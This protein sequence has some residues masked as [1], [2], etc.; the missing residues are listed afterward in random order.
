LTGW[1][2]A[3]MLVAAVLVF[4]VVYLQTGASL[5]QQI[6]VDLHSDVNQ[7][8]GSLKARPG[9]TTERVRAR[10]VRYVHT[11]PYATISTLLFVLMPGQAPA[12]NHP[13]LFGALPPELGESQAVQTH[14]NREAAR[15]ARPRLGYSVGHVPDVGPM[16]ILERAARVGGVRVVAGAAEPLDSVDAAQR[17]VA[18]AF[19]LAGALALV[20]ALV[21]SYVAG[22]RVTA[23]LRRLAGVAARVDSGELEPRMEEPAG[24]GEEVR[25]LADAFNHMLDRLAVAF[26]GQREFMADASHELRTPLTVIRGQLE[27]LAATD[28]PSPEEVK[29]VERVVQAEV[30]RMSR[31]VDDLLLLTAAERSDFLRPEAIDVGPFAGELWDGLSLTAE[32]RFELGEVPEGTL[33]ADPDRVAQA[34]RNLG[35][36]AIDHSA[37]HTGLVRL[38]VTDLGSGRLSFAVVDDG[39]GIP[40]ADRERVFERL[41]RIDPSRSRVAGG[42]GLGLS[43]VR[44]IV[45]AHGGEV[46]IDSVPG[47]RGARVEFVLPG[48]VAAPGG[49]APGP[50]Y[51]RPV[52]QGSNLADSGYTG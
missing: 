13:E 42:A 12:S 35:R 19:G 6:D 48:F 3:V 51:P 49:R 34:I 39:P 10:A 45:E 33:D 27:V 43:I 16:R 8:L 50:P 32:R 26:Q 44:A 28:R 30:T 18:R 20:L 5:Q 22:E 11:Q 40:A 36:N 15:L 21:A 4:A 38:E 37:E 14:E 29:R 7:M 46:K 52:A 23:P 31:L 24:G 47:G 9:H 1:V 2:A 41:Y 25:V 17:S